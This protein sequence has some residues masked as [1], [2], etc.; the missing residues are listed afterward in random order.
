MS[1][2]QPLFPVA[3]EVGGR[4]CLVV[5]AGPVATRKAEALLGS[6]AVVTV[7]APDVDQSMLALAQ[8]P[9]GTAGGSLQIEQRPYRAGEAAEYRLVIT[10]TGI[11]EVDGAVFADAEAAQV[12]V[13]SAD[14]VEHCTFILPAVH[15]DGVV[16]IAISTGGASPA[17]ASW[18]RRRMGEALEAGLGTMAAILE[19]ARLALKADG[20]STEGAAWPALLDGPFPELVRQGRFSEARAMVEEVIGVRL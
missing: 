4:E 15:R 1:L 14:D 11:P 9:V 17:L 5:G 7:V 19:E 12:W 8:G 18:L 20:R 10:S 16:S 13:N 6:G 3:L 2:R